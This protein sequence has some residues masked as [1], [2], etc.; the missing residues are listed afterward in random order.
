MP[1]R[2]VRSPTC[3]FLGSLFPQHIEWLANITN[4]KTRRAYKIDVGEFSA[5]SGQRTG[6]VDSVLGIRANLLRLLFLGPAST[7]APHSFLSDVPEQAFRIRSGALRP[8]TEVKSRWIIRIG[9]C[10]QLSNPSFER[11]NSWG[12]NP[13][14]GEFRVARAREVGGALLT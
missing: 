13:K 7:V 14:Q 4:K 12:G 11:E 10:V 8:A 2:T 3:G 9:G 5:T 1:H 6:S